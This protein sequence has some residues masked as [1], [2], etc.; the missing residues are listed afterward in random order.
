MHDGSP[1]AARWL[2]LDRRSF[3]ATACVAQAEILS[4]MSG[5]NDLKEVLQAA[6]ATGGG[7]Q[8]VGAIKRIEEF[9]AL[10]VGRPRMKAPP[11]HMARGA[12]AGAAD[13]LATARER[14]AAYERLLVMV[15]QA[16]WRETQ[17]AGRVA[18]AE[19]AGAARTAEQLRTRLDTAVELGE[20]IAESGSGDEPALATER[21]DDASVAAAAL[22]AWYAA[23]P[24]V[25]SPPAVP[26]QL[27]A[28]VE[29]AGDGSA[30]A[31]IVAS[32]DE[33][34]RLVS[35]LETRLPDP[36]PAV[37]EA[38]MQA[39]RHWEAARRGAARAW[40]LVGGG[41]FVA[42]AG[43]ALVVA[44]LPRAG[45]ALL[46]VSGAV[47]LVGLLPP[48]RLW[49]GSPRAG[50]DAAERGARP[51]GGRHRGGQIDPR[52]GDHPLR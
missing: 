5:V 9:H 47:A 15:E 43:V 10:M 18:R 51:T 38:A 50:L 8:P 17:A 52:G 37:A 34:W 25:G 26:R 19:W 3:R 12:R 27:A 21:A 23:A 48:S 2:G 45:I 13:A 31:V 24:S 6:A 11:I 39:R 30:V 36:D 28:G 46:V 14:H 49:S 41:M 4:V 44:G 32:E 29:P 16:R 7:G 1:D 33:M 22:Y 35:D 42:L 20:L 40:W